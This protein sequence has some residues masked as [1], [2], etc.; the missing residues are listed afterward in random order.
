[1]LKL[2]GDRNEISRGGG[3]AVF[4]ISSKSNQFTLLENVKDFERC[5]ILSHTDEGP[6]LMACWYRPP[7]QGNLDCIEAFR[8]ELQTH[9]VGAMGTVVIGD[10][11]VHSKR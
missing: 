1:M 5:W 4:A 6:I 7:R 8:E 3:I 10:I 9:R 2:A 11:N